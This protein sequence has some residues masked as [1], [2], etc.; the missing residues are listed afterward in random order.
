MKLTIICEDG[1]VYKD[2]VSYSNLDLSAVPADVHA[3]Q[4][5][6]V[7]NDGWVEFTSPIPNEEITALPV[8][9][10]TAMAKW[11]EAEAARLAAE[12]AKRLAAEQTKTNN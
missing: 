5:N 1:A 9:A 12:E 8:W 7:S 4:F 11:D 6:D 10:I 3:L 2:G